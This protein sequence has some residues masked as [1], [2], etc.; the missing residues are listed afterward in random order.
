M[1]TLLL[2]QSPRRHLVT[3]H[4]ILAPTAGLRS[5]AVPRPEDEDHADTE[6]EDLSPD[7]TQK[8]DSAVN[9]ALRRLVGWV[10]E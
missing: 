4:G 2:A 3:C 7:R 9:L 5:R 6:P 10:K 8:R 1:V